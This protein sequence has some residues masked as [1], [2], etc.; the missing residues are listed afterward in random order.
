MSVLA[1]IFTM[2]IDVSVLTTILH[3]AQENNIP[4]R[5]TMEFE[6]ETLLIQYGR[7]PAQKVA[8]V[9]CHCLIFLSVVYLTTLWIAQITWCRMSHSACLA[10]SVI[11]ETEAVY[12]FETS[13]NFFHI[14]RRCILEDSSTLYFYFVTVLIRHLSFEIN[15][16]F[17]I[18]QGIKNAVTWA[19]F[20]YDGNGAKILRLH[21]YFKALSAN[22]FWCC[23]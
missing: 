17:R 3:S 8:S 21:K 23:W 20:F 2:P 5:W 18:L 15:D 14:R 11:R 13:I 1:T 12:V 9:R 6:Q 10:Y 16:L 19:I 4:H 22:D 7:G